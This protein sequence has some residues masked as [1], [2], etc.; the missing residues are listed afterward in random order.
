MSKLF[1]NICLFIWQLPQ[2]LIGCCVYLVNIKS[3]LKCEE[4]GVVYYTAKH[5]YDCGVSLGK[6]IFLDSDI[7]EP[8]KEFSKSIKHEHGHQKQ[9]LYLGWLY[10][11]IIGFPSVIGNLID[12][13]NHNVHHSNK[14]CWYY[15]Q[16]WEYWADK[17]GGVDR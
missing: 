2:N 7:H 5:V 9:S 10:I 15:K 12:R 6:F 16:P 8:D 17:L 11:F 4:D 14:D 3:V 13:C 1:K